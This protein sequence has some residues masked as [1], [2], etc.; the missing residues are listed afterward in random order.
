MAHTS[1]G[2]RPLVSN[3]ADP[4]R[5]ALR[6]LVPD[7]IG[8]SRCP[9]AADLAG[10]LK[11]MEHCPGRLDPLNPRD[12]DFAGDRCWFRCW[13]SPVRRRNPGSNAFPGV[14]KGTLKEQKIKSEAL[15]G[16]ANVSRFTRR[17]T[18]TPRRDECGLLR[19]F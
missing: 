18:T 4:Q 10:Q 14:P 7:R 5:C 1:G 3:R 11:V 8:R 19:S 12:G 9:E 16:G 15:K 17:Q 6:L 2:H 13:N